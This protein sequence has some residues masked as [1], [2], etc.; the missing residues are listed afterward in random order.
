M[1]P[2]EEVGKASA[3]VIEALKLQPALLVLVVLQIVLLVI[4][5][6]AGAQQRTADRERFNTVMQLCGPKAE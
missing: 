5:A 3:G 4:V 6:W 1:G 2:V